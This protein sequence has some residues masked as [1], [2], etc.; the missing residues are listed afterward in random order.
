VGRSGGYDQPAVLGSSPIRPP[1]DYPTWTSG[2]W[3]GK[4]AL[5]F[6]NATKSTALSHFYG[7]PDNRFFDRAVGADAC[8]GG[9]KPDD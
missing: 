9:A 6:G 7:L 2:R 1:K 8:R 4:S 3:P 5:S